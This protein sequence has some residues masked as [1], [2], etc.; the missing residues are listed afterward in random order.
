[1]HT[2]VVKVERCGSGSGWEV[3]GGRWAGVGLWMRMFLVK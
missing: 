1:M 2:V 3:G